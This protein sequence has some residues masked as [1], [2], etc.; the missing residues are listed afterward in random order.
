MKKL[1][2]ER[3]ETK[4]QQSSGITLIA[5]VITI[6]VLLI[7]AAISLTMLTGDNS[8]LKRAGVE[9]EATEIAKDKELIGIANNQAIIDE[10][11]L[12]RITQENMQKQIDNVF[13]EYK[14][15]KVYAEDEDFYVLIEKRLY[16][17][18]KDKKIELLE[19]NFEFPKKIFS[20][21][22]SN[23]E[24]GASEDKPYEIRCIEDLLDFSLSVNG[25]VIENNEITYTNNR[26]N[27]DGKYVSLVKNLDFKLPLTYENASRTDYGDINR[28]GKVENL[29]TELTTGKGWI[30]IGGYG[31]NDTGVFNGNFNG[32]DNTI[33]HLYINN[34]IE[35]KYVALFG[36]IDR[37]NIKRIHVKGNIYCNSARACG[38]AIAV[39]HNVKSISNCTFDGKVRNEC[40]GSSQTA[41]IIAYTGLR[42]TIN[43]C[44]SKGEIIGNNNVG[45]IVGHGEDTLISDSNNDANITGH[46]NVGGIAGRRCQSIINCFNIG[47]VNGVYVVGGIIGQTSSHGAKVFRCYNLSKISGANHVGG[48][49]GSNHVGENQIFEQCYNKGEI[50]GISKVGGI[51]GL[52]GT[53]GKRNS[54]INCYNSGNLEGTLIA[55]IAF[56]NNN[57]NIKMISCYNYGILNSNKKYEIS[58]RGNIKNCYY[59]SNQETATG[60]AEEVTSEQLKNLAPT[61]DKAHTIDEETGEITISETETQKVWKEDTESK[62]QGYPI[63]AWQ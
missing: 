31:Q 18:N 50:V 3:K 38:I 55:G 21:Q 9:K 15:A 57:V 36:A 24:L 8:I 54:I 40:K 27:F 13:G 63:F 6:I 49:I 39:N 2:F 20:T 4:K 16:K 52:I 25:I 61:L 7:L 17:I 22:M 51:G 45:G 56:V 53:N 26:K 29:L 5:L 23:N 30:P 44:T 60:N 47:M 43:K 28:D 34:I 46:T 14:N 62:N 35:T 19:A 59:I 41:G 12:D 58:D 10:S 32:N 11:G 48:I 33:S 1:K 42:C 37:T